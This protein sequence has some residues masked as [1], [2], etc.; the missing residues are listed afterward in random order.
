MN[1]IF[2][3]SVQRERAAPL[4]GVS[5]PDVRCRRPA[6]PVRLEKTTLILHIFHIPRIITHNK[7]FHSFTSKFL[8]Y[9]TRSQYTSILFLFILFILFFFQFSFIPIE[10]YR[11]RFTPV[12]R[13]SDTSVPQHLN[14]RATYNAFKTPCWRKPHQKHV[15]VTEY[16]D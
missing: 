6:R 14:Y 2:C 1:L 8:T 3:V 11:A 10:N 12:N 16:L 4:E 5:A 9:T 13:T 7:R 15:P